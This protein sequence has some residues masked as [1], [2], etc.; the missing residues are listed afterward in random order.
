MKSSSKRLSGLRFYFPILTIGMLLFTPFAP[1]LGF[2]QELGTLK[3]VYEQILKSF[4]QNLAE[5]RKS[6][7]KFQEVDVLN[8]AG[9]A[10]RYLNQYQKA[11]ALHQQALAIARAIQDR[12]RESEVLRN[13][14]TDYAK[15]GDDYGINFYQQ[16]LALMRQQGDRTSQGIVLQNLGIAYLS[17]QNFPKAVETYQLYLPIVRDLKDLQQEEAALSLLAGAYRGAGEKQKILPVLER[18]L[19]IARELKNPTLERSALFD[20]ATT[21]RYDYKEQQA[22]DLYQQVLQLSQTPADTAYR[23]IVLQELA[24]L[25]AELNNPAKVIELLEQTLAIAV[26]TNNLFQQSMTLEALS[27]THSLLGD[28]PKAI[29]LQKQSLSRYQAFNQQSQQPASLSEAQGLS[30]LGAILFRAGKLTESE[31]A[32]LAAIKS[33]DL[34]RQQASSNQ[35]LLALTRDDLNL[36]LRSGLGDVYQTLQQT[37]VAQNKFTAALEAAEASRARAFVDLLASRLGT[38]AKAQAS[39]P[40]NLQQMQQIAQRQKATLVQY[41][42]I[43]DDIRYSRFRLGKKPPREA[44][45]L[46][47]VIQPQGQVAFRQVDLKGTQPGEKSLEAI[48]AEA[49]D[50]IGARGRGFSFKQNTDAVARALASLESGSKTNRPL[51]QLHQLLIQPIASLLPTDPK[52]HV[53]FI[54]QESLFLVPFP[55]LQDPEGTYLVEKHTILTAPSIQVLDLTRQQ[56]QRNQGTAKGILVVG[57]PTMPSIA[58]R[59]GEPAEQLPALPGSEQEAKEI[60]TLLKTEPIL[61]SQAT[62]AAIVQRMPQSRIIHLATHG[63]L[64]NFGGFQSS[65]ALA[66]VGKEDGLLTVRDILSLKLNAELVVLSACD[67]GRGRISGDGVIGLSRSFIAAGASSI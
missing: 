51:Q 23:G 29:D 18:R 31:T 49:R 17:T 4:D 3:A 35:N 16:Q 10:A 41:S 45:L 32:L 5:A 36:G 38:A 47:W 50:A 24:T 15:L 56:R 54:P 1:S 22:I 48:V 52:A 46:I 37:L 65:L 26:Q 11:V 53:I 21:Y 43:Y 63:L 40:P 58:P 61:G 12:G 34:S 33:H 25:Y 9:I 14:A 30:H 6:G 66:P 28:Y 59:V 60:A 42:V 20:L 2:A 13:L 67:T 44:R 64:D 55:A 27:R 39:V 62:E 57:N 8:S 7:A 19:A